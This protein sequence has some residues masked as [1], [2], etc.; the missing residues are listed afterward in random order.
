MKNISPCDL[1]P[2]EMKNSN[3]GQE[4]EESSKKG[5]ESDSGDTEHKNFNGK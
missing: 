4:S 2:G 1:D 5:Y 3:K